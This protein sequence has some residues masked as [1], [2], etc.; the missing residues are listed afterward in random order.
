MTG[1]TKKNVL[2]IPVLHKHIIWMNFNENIV[3]LSK[4]TSGEKISS[5]LRNIENIIETK[6]FVRGGSK[7]RLTNMSMHM[8]FPLIWFLHR[9]LVQ[10]AGEVVGGAAIHV[11]ASVDQV[12]LRLSVPV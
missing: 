12:G 5:Y 9:E 10:I 2:R 1:P 3:I 11:P 7:G 6:W 8:V 4:F